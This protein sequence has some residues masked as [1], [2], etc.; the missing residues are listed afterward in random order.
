[1]SIFSR[2]TARLLGR[3]LGIDLDKWE[4][5]QIFMSISNP[6]KGFGE[7][8]FGGRT[9]RIGARTVIAV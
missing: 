7:D 3:E 5:A 8:E 1:M 4:A 9:L 2:Q 6:E